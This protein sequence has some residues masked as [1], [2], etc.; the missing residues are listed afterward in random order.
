MREDNGIGTGS[1]RSYQLW[2]EIDR[3]VKGIIRIEKVRPILYSSIAQKPYI[4]LNVGSSPCMY[5]HLLNYPSVKALISTEHPTLIFALRNDHSHSSGNLEILE[6]LIEQITVPPLFERIAY[7]SKVYQDGFQ[8]ICNA[9]ISNNELR[10]NPGRIL[11]HLIYCQRFYLWEHLIEDYGTS[12][13]SDIQ[14]VIRSAKRLERHLDVVHLLSKN[15]EKEG[16]TISIDEVYNEYKTFDPYISDYY[17][18][19]SR[20]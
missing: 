9:T 12:L 18:L 10:I 1:E 19:D 7:L 6:S 17:R 8:L 16:E 11:S 15:L 2:R 5:I 4:E 3:I 13:K 20:G 14:T